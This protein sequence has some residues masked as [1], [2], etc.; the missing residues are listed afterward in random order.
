MS[1]S[2]L[3]TQTN[4]GSGAVVACVDRSP[5]AR[6]VANAAAELASTLA[7]PLVLFHVVETTTGQTQR[8]D[9]IEWKLR[10]QQAYNC[11]SQMRG[12]LA[13]DSE[14]ITIEV[15]EA[16]LVRAIGD[17][18][19]APG[20]ILVIGANG[21][22]EHPILRDRTAQQVLHASVAPVL[23]VPKGKSISE[24]AFRRILVPIDGSHFSD[25]ALE[26]ASQLAKKSGAELLLA[27]VVPEAGLTSLG[28]PKTDDVELLLRLNQRNEAAGS[29]LLEQTARRVASQGLKVRSVCRKGDARPTLLREIY[30]ERPSLVILSARGQGGRNC[31]DLPIGST[32]SYLLDHLAVPTM[33]IPASIGKTE[34]RV[35]PAPDYRMHAPT[36]AA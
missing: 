6:N 31:L 15:V 17:R 21:S 20:T 36:Y 28:P 9:P 5:D 1:P 13:L 30:E 24:S 19:A 16:E 27:H 22:E 26:T 14:A 35:I 32:A 4:R 34:R 8:P 7:L 29:D 3:N 12:R 23:V 33:L 18:G 25:I 10:R 11:L 2:P